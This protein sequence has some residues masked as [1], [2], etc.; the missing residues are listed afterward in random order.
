MEEIK[1]IIDGERKNV[2][3]LSEYKSIVG[4]GARKY[5]ENPVAGVLVNGKISSLSERIE[6]KEE[7]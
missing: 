4:Y 2:G 6:G 7:I 3:F 1:V 5:E